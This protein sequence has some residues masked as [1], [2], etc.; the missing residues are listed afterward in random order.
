MF[1]K[2]GWWTKSKEKWNFE[3]QDKGKQNIKQKRKKRR[4]LK[5]SLFREQQKTLKLQENSQFGP[6]TKQKHKNTEQNQQNHQKNKK[7]DKKHL[8]HFGKQPPIFGKFLFFFKFHSFMFLQSCVLQKTL[9]RGVFSRA[10]LLGI[11]DT[12]RGPF[13]KWHFCNQ[14]CH[15]GFPL[16]LLK[17]Q[18]CSVWWLCMGTK[19]RT[20]SP[21]QIVAAKMRA[22]CTFRTQLVFAY[23]SK[24][25]IKKSI[26]LHNHPKTQFFCFFL[27]FSFSNFVIF[28][29]LLCPT[30]KDKN[31]KHFSKPLLWHLNNLQRNIF[32]PLHTICVF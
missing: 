17:P 27:K 6:F 20:I 25:A 8:L 12:S 9:K 23:F 15:M 22:F 30:L 11:T 13:P 19:K 32:A 26:F 2:R 7:T 24:N 18:F 4:I 31:K 10:Q 16:C 21:K 3:R 28:S 1:S 29:L 14:K 5:T